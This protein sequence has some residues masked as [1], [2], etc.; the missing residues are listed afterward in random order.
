MILILV[1]SQAFFYYFLYEVTL[2]LEFR[3]KS[4]KYAVYLCFCI[5]FLIIFYTLV[6]L[7]IE[8]LYL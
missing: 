3:R 2:E 8:E 5:N 6:S 7:F 4:M 1:I